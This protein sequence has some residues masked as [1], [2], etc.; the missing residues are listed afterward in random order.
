M[1]RSLI[2]TLCLAGIAFGSA[3]TKI[4]TYAEDNNL[5]LQQIRD[6]NLKTLMDANDIELTNLD[7]RGRGK[8]KKKLVAWY[9]A[10][11]RVTKLDALQT[12]IRN[13]PQCDAADIVD[14]DPDANVVMIYIDG[15]PA[16]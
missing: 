7:L 10:K 15:L 5:T 3:Y 6:M 9:R 11:V 4:V 14:I 2:I 8:L 1:K 12:A 16:E 13:I